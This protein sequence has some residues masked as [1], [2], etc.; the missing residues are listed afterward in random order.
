M[1]IIRYN[2]ESQDD[3]VNEKTVHVVGVRG[4]WNLFDNRAQSEEWL[5]LKS[6]Q[7][8]IKTKMGCGLP[9]V[10][11]FYATDDEHGAIVYDYESFG[12][13]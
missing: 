6:I 4:L 2:K 11:N 1:A 5:K 10:V 3:T 8:N 12:E 9:I 13:D 7:S